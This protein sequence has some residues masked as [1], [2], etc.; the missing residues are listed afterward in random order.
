MQV[1]TMI[2][3]KFSYLTIISEPFK[4]LTNDKSR[5]RKFITVECDCGKIKEVNFGDLKSKKIKS[6]GCKAIFLTQEALITHGLTDHPLYEVWASM[7][8]RCDNPNSFKYYDYGGRGI[9]YQESWVDFNSFYEDMNIGYSED[10][11]LD[12]ADTN[13]NYTKENCR[14]VSRGINCHNRR[15]RKGSKCEAIGVCQKE[16]KFRAQLT[17]EGKTVFRKTFL[18]ENEAA[19]AYDDASEEYYGDRPNKTVKGVIP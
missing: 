17:F 16:N 11:E 8:K 18:T 15:K 5:S 1:E 13:G 2:G 19:L 3:V 10:L 7:K 12:R 4:K 6:C 9:S 14:W